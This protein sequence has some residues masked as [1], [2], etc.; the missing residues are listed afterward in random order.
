MDEKQTTLYLVRHGTTDLNVKMCF[1]GALDI[2]LNALGLAQGDRLYHYF[3][4]IPIDVAV[5]SPLIRAQQTLEALLGDRAYRYDIQIESDLTEI[6]GGVLEG[7]SMKECAV[8]FPAFME[9]MGAHPGAVNPPGGEPGP[10]VY[11]RVAEAINGLVREHQGKTIVAVSHGFSIQT[12]LN[13]AKGIPPEAM[14][15]EVLP[16]VSVSKFTFDENFKITID[17]IGDNSHLPEDMQ[18]TYNWEELTMEEPVFLCYPRC[19]TCKKARKFLEDHGVAYT[20]RHIVEDPLTKEEI[21][22]LMDRYGG[23]P[24]RF[25]NTSGM[26]YRELALKDIV[27]NMDAEDMAVWLATDGMLVKRPQLILKDKVCVGFKEQ[28]WAEA[29]G[30]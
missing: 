20:E 26:R 16:N 11:N 23:E 24:K 4:E 10:M 30:L 9:A 15:E 1:Q 17:Y 12:W 3:K 28:E 19:S 13:Y 22:V 8:F 18:Q 27:P 2:P 14:E 6:N 21:L 7:R 25:F 5:S 29:L